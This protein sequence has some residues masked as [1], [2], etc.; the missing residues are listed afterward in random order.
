M[1]LG[2]IHCGQTQFGPEKKSI[3]IFEPPA[4]SHWFKICIQRPNIYYH[5]INRK[6][7]QSFFTTFYSLQKC[8]F[9]CKI[10]IKK[11]LKYHYAEHRNLIWLVKYYW[12]ERFKILQVHFIPFFFFL[13]LN[14]QIIFVR[15]TL[16]VCLLIV[17]VF[18][19]NNKALFRRRDTQL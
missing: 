10:K 12:E 9:T 14:I 18:L 11:R 16:I 2:L 13:Y 17:Q 6:P 15:N 7:A 3:Y 8:I 19:N 1:C 5:S 4:P